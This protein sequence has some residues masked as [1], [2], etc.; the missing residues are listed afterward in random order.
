MAKL[1][2]LVA[3]LAGLLISPLTFAAAGQPATPPG[4]IPLSIEEFIE[5][6]TGDNPP[7]IIDSRIA[8]DYERGRIEGAVNLTDT[9]MT[10]ESLAAIAAK[11]MP[12]L[13]YCNGAEC[14]RSV[15]AC[16]KAVSW[17]WTDVMWYP[18]GI[19]EWKANDLPLIR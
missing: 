4:V 17:G 13:F 5:F 3:A 7:V 8:A 11:D 12:V 16:T 18:G 19:N 2:S 10:P 1:L 6:A 14:E 9:E 15:N